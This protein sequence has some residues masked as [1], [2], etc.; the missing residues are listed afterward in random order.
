MDRRE[1]MK[2]AGTGLLGAAVLPPPDAG[3]PGRATPEAVR[4]LERRRILTFNSVIRVNQIEV[5]RTR[6]EGFDEA[7]IHTP[8]NVGALREAFAA[9]WPG[10]PG[11]DRQRQD[12]R[13][14]PAEPDRHV[15]RFRSRLAR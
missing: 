11:A 10:A 15:P 4:S 1:F 13:G 14:R 9:G 2:K 12:R 5:T 6:N 8:E 7:A 3:S